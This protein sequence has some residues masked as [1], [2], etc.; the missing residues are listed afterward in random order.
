MLN[1]LVS[2]KSFAQ[3]TVPTTNEVKMML[4][5]IEKRDK[6]LASAERVI[7]EC[8]ELVAQYEVQTIKYEDHIKLLEDIDANKFA[9]YNLVVEKNT[10]LNEE[11]VVANKK[12]KFWKRMT[13]AVPV[14]LGAA[15]TYVFY[16]R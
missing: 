3:S 13:V 1:L 5:I 9:T 14:V 12:V 2:L 7:F 6:E 11:L 15:A 8:K 16:I 10:A 4:A